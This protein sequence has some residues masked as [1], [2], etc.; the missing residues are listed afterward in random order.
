MSDSCRACGRPPAA[1]EPESRN[2]TEHT[3]C[4]ET[5]GL[6]AIPPGGRV[7]G[8]MHKGLSAP[9]LTAGQTNSLP[10]NR[11]CRAADLTAAWP[12]AQAASWRPPLSE[13]RLGSRQSSL[14][15]CA[16]GPRLRGHHTQP[17]AW[18]SCRTCPGAIVG[19][20]A[21]HVH[22]PA[23][24]REAPHAAHELPV[25]HG[26]VLR[27]IGDA[28]QEQGA[29]QIQGPGDAE[30]TSVRPRKREG[31]TGALPLPWGPCH[32]HIQLKCQ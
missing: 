19:D 16:G 20:E 6:L 32:R 15:G 17:G 4:A 7:S 29:G 28:P 14:P 26:E 11:P 13:H 10:T 9:G 1:R 2:G 12:H 5:L 24:H 25:V 8:D 23:V 3:A 31:A 27:K 22:A 21:G 18:C 30:P